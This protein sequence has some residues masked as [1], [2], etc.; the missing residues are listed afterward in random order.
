MKRSR[1]VGQALLFLLPFTWMPPASRGAGPQDPSPSE[2][3]PARRGWT[4]ELQLTYTVQAVV[5]GGWE[6][7]SFEAFSD[8][9]DVGHTASADLR[10]LFDTNEAGLWDGGLFAGRAEA[11]A[12]RS[13]LQRAGGA[14]AVNND[15]LFPNV[16]DRFD[17]EALA[18]TE[19]SFTQEAGGGISLFAGLLN[20]AEGDENEIAG[21]A[22]SNATFLNAALL[23]SLVEDATVPNVSLGGGAAIQAGEALSGSVSAFG[24]AET[25]GENPFKPGRGITYCSEWTFAYAV[26]GRP[27]ALTAG[28]LYGIDARRADI[29]AD[30]RRLLADVLLSRTPPTTDADTWAAYWNG[31]QFLSGDVEGGWG[32][33]ARAG[34]SDGDPNPVRWNAAL[35]AGGIGSIPGRPRDRW[36][37]GV[38]TVGLSDED[39]LEAVGVDRESGGELFY[40]LAVASRLLLTADVQVVDPGLPGRDRAWILGARMHLVF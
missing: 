37:L 25:A 16:E 20:P 32:V 33:F 19:L 24:T 7:P 2:P 6:G 27:G 15:A 14:A 10:I 12:G 26:K 5:D 40:A 13:I 3:G 21:A 23:Y 28:F 8:E 4:L 18:L 9:E 11:R 22:L 38:F 1:R 36:G 31:H 35:G 29:A 17:A 39:L 30:P 34:L